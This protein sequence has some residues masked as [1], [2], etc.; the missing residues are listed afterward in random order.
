MVIRPSILSIMSCLC[1]SSLALAQSVWGP[2][3]TPVYSFHRPTAGGAAPPAEDWNDPY[4]K[5]AWF[6]FQDDSTNSLG[7]EVDK[8]FGWVATNVGSATLVI[9]GTNTKGKVKYARLYNGV[10]QHHVWNRPAD[11]ILPPTTQF[12]FTAWVKAYTNTQNAYAGIAVGQTLNY[13]LFSDSAGKG[14]YAATP[15]AAISNNTMTT[16]WQHICGVY[17]G[18]KSLLYIDGVLQAT[19]GAASGNKSDYYQLFI[20][21]YNPTT[22]TR[23]WNG[24]IGYVGIYTNAFTPANVT[25]HFTGTSMPNGCM[26]VGY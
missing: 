10:D 21:L 7:N 18:S 22:P 16:G 9:A 5:F 4:N 23:R 17:D 20:G 8:Q 12:T 3:Q 19:G 24:L 26:E 11:Y 13:G 14:F 1:A 6:V 15:T 25:N 2:A